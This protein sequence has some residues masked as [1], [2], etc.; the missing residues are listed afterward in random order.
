M[1]VAQIYWTDTVMGAIRRCMTNGKKKVTVLDGL[2]T[3]EA[4]TV[5]KGEGKIYYSEWGAVDAISRCNLDGTGVEQLITS[6]TGCRD[7]VLDVPNGKLYYASSSAADE[8]IGR[9]NLDGSGREDLVTGIRA[10]GLGLDLVN[11]EMYWTD[12]KPNPD[13]ISKATMEGAG[14]ADVVASAPSGFG[15]EIDTDREKMYWV[16]WP[17]TSSVRRADLDGG[18]AEVLITSATDGFVYITLDIKKQKMYFNRWVGATSIDLRVA[19]F[20]GTQEKV[21]WSASQA[22]EDIQSIYLVPGGR[23]PKRRW[24]RLIFLVG[25]TVSR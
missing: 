9:A 17:G 7:I 8:R 24:D 6:E 10:S 18:N 15:I 23:T 1:G 16:D 19:N 25:R 12:K 3:P 4:I 11:R 20:D 22:S 5:D 2:D 21:L 13:K 14:T